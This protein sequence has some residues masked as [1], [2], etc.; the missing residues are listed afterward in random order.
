MKKRLA[1]MFLALM[2]IIMPFAG[3]TAQDAVGT[4]VTE[5]SSALQIDSTYFTDR[6]SKIDYEES[7]A[8]KIVLSSTT[9]K[10]TGDG[11]KLEDKTV[12]ITKEGTYILSGSSDGLNVVVEAADT[13]K[14]WLVFDN[15]SMK[16]VSAPIQVLTADKV[17]ITLAK[18]STN[19]IED[20]EVAESE[21]LNA[22]IYS[23]SDL[24]INGSGKLI[25]NGKYE[26][27]IKSSDDLKM[28]GGSFVITAANDGLNANDAL[29]IKDS[30]IEISAKGDG[31]HSD[32]NVYI[33]GKSLNI[34]ES[35]EGIEGKVVDIVSG[36]IDIKSSDDGINATDSSLKTDAVSSATPAGDEQNKNLEERPAP[37]EGFGQKPANFEDLPADVQEKIKNRPERPEGEAVPEGEMQRPEGMP[38]GAGFE[39][40]EGTEI[41]IR[42][43]DLY[44]DAS[45]DGIDSN[46]NLT[47]SGGKVVIEGSGSRGDGAIDYNGT[48]L[49]TG[50]EVLALGGSDMLQ[51][52]SSESAQSHIVVT[53]KESIAVGAK[54][55]I[56]DEAGKVLYEHITKKAFSA[57]VYSSKDLVKAKNYTVQIGDTILETISK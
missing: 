16:G 56:K 45:G 31:I 36:D 51:S 25:V 44:I 34:K 28:L 11:A 20:I 38:H 2:L 18:G 32:K 23:K 26:H 19:T 48:G 1:G 57:L 17:F 53:A 10:I 12:K 50:G 39:N 37:P 3:C 21:E 22:A 54:I 43:G 4:T 24:T 49:V 6:D 5:A 55:T 8:S 47:V 46:G 27:G 33:D 14:V 42:G 30:V 13:E 29:N 40:Q 52:F 35:E 15:L 7:T 41:I 9:A